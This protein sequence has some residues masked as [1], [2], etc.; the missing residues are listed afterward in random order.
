MKTSI[1]RSLPIL[2]LLALAL[3][4]PAQAARVRRVVA[5][6]TDTFQVASNTVIAVGT[7]RKASLS[8]IHVGDRVGISY[9]A[10]NGGNVARHISDGVPHKPRTQNPNG[11]P[12]PK[13]HAHPAQSLLHVHGTVQAVDVEG[14]TITVSHR[15][16]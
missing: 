14:A 13:P 4:W 9:L 11:T 16:K 10:E 2:A 7:N 12:P 8:D 3:A 6:Q 1:A 5:Y 15:P